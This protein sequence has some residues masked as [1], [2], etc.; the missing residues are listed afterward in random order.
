MSDT[1][2][3]GVIW[4]KHALARL[5]E[6]GLSQ[7]TVLQA[8]RHPDSTRSGK[9]RGTTEFLS[10]FDGSEI[11]VVAAKNEQGEWVI[12]SCWIDPPLPGTKDWYRKQ[13][14]LAY[15]KAGFWGKLWR[16]VLRQLG[17]YDW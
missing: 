15:Q 13:R 11:S 9:G 8:F 14:Y 5:R 16:L 2:Y 10:T 6:R 17:L 1:H 7:Q 12:I 4:T 3:G